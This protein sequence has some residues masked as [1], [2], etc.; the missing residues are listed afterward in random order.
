MEAKAPVMLLVLVETARLGWLVAAVGLDGH[1]VPLL[2]SEAGDLDRYPGL[3]FDD[4]V[5]FL[6]HRFC[7]VLQRGCDRLWARGLKARQFVILF[8]GPLGDPTGTLTHAV[9]EH[10]VQ[11]MLNPPAAVFAGPIGAG[12]GETHRFDKLAGDLDP[13]WEKPLSA[14]LNG[15]SAAREDPSLWELA[16]KK[17]S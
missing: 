6:R 13:A 3:D 5:A 7:G 8:E 9:A 17:V 14:S 1:V 2:R 4:Q 15:I 11:W 12:A 10:F 16:R